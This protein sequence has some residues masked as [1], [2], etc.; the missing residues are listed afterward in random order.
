MET[1]TFA[2]EGEPYNKPGFN[3]L[4]LSFK[5]FE[6]DY[7][8][9]RVRLVGKG[10]QQLTSALTG[11]SGKQFDMR[12]EEQVFRGCQIVEEYTDSAV[13]EYVSVEEVDE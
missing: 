12:W 11:Y 10:L 2:K 6:P 1:V 3:D 13:I 9:T 5:K 7:E 4:S 8:S